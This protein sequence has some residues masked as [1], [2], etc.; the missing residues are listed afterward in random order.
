[1]DAGVHRD[2]VARKSRWALP[3]GFVFVPCLP[4]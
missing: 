1:M 4:D 2:G 3:G